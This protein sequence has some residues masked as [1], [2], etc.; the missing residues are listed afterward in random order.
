ME[1][2]RATSETDANP[3]TSGGDGGHE[4][5]SGLEAP[6]SLLESRSHQMFP[7]LTAAEI[8]RIH[9]F[10]EVRSWRAGEMLFSTGDVGAACTS[11]CPAARASSSGTGWVTAAPLPRKGPASFWRRSGN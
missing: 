2:T 11:S 9:R 5:V 1:M 10:G 4:P 8:E 3:D 7:T 6:Y